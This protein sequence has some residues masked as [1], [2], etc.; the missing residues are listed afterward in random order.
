M[1]NVNTMSLLITKKSPSC[2]FIVG[3]IFIFGLLL[4]YH[5]CI[6]T[7]LIVDERLPVEIAKTISFDGRQLSL[8]L[9]SETYNHP[10]LS[11]YAIKAAFVVFGNNMAGLAS[12][13]ILVG[14]LTLIALFFLVRQIL[15]EK[16]ALL[17]MLLLCVN[18]YHISVSRMLWH[19]SGLLFFTTLMLLVFVLALRYKS[20][21]LMLSL[22][23]LGG[24]GYLNKETIIIL[25]PIFLV[26]LMVSRKNAYWLRKKEAY[27]SLLIAL[28]IISPDVWWNL[29]Q[30][31][32]NYRFWLLGRVGLGGFNLDPLSFFL[33]KLF[34]QDYIHGF[35][36]VSWENPIMDWFNGSIILLGAV[37]ALVKCRAKMKLLIIMFWGIFFV[38]TFLIRAQESEFWWASMMII[39]GVVFAAVM[40]T[41]L[42]ERRRIFRY[43]INCVVVYLVIAAFIPVSITE[44]GYP[45]N[46]FGRIADCNFSLVRYY[47]YNN[48]VGNSIQEFK[49]ILTICPNEIRAHNGLGVCFAK[50]GLF[51]EAKAEWKR[52]LRIDSGYEYAKTNLRLLEGQEISEH[53]FLL[54]LD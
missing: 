31:N 48:D 3:A 54:D 51:K 16:R 43:A 25:A 24:V 11:I 28:L 29:S 33:M 9:G 45:P 40:L 10:M 26:Y 19:E 35:E 15:D 8:P 53:Q 46:R 50:Q 12:P 34:P 5:S 47:F 27:I 32:S 30:G 18:P 44:D 7:E 14:S 42:K 23:L 2:W 22:G 38:F 1:V 13:F 49:R 36:M 39:P 37:Y 6:T 21:K 52:A 20:S 4:R 17:A 41:D